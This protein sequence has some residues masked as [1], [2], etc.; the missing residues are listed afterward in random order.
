MHSSLKNHLSNNESANLFNE[1]FGEIIFDGNGKAKGNCD[2]DL[3]LTAV[4]D[5]FELQ[6]SGV[7]LVSSD[8]DYSP[9]I[10]FW[11]EKGVACTVLSPAIKDRCSILIKR[12][13]VSIVC[14]NDVR[15]KLEYRK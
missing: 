5:Y 13:G 3:V 15:H 14:L 10:K 12:T 7:V 11:Q 6:P 9:L 8:G 2:A 4:R 1:T